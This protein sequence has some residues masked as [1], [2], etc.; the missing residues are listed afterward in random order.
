VGTT[1]YGL[2]SNRGSSRVQSNAGTPD[3]GFKVIRFLHNFG[4]ILVRGHLILGTFIYGFMRPRV[5]ILLGFIFRRFCWGQR[6]LGSH[7]HGFIRKRVHS[8]TVSP[9]FGAPT[10]ALL[11]SPQKRINSILYKL[12][13][14]VPN[15]KLT[16]Y[17]REKLSPKWTVPVML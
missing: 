4:F 13:G 11:R 17:P 9:F 12:R 5:A 2:K 1:F 14:R 15:S 8:Y 16:L 7:I 6:N 3:C 10:Y